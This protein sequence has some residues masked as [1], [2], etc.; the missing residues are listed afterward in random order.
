MV[1]THAHVCFFA[2]SQDLGFTAKQL[3]KLEEVLDCLYLS[4]ELD[5]NV[6]RVD[7][8]VSFL[9]DSLDDFQRVSTRLQ[10]GAMHRHAVQV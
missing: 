2:C 3:D 6:V 7:E 4:C 5:C 1:M 10:G 8:I 9:S